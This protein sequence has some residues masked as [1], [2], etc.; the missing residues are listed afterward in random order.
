MA[1]SCK[2]SPEGSSTVAKPRSAPFT[3]GRKTNGSPGSTSRAREAPVGFAAVRDQDEILPSNVRPSTAGS[4]DPRNGRSGGGGALYGPRPLDAQP[5][6][7]GRAA[8]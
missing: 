4:T 8:D 2:T 1:T 5:L 6:A 7:H 3:S